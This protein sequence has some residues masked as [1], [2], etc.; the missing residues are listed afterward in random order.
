MQLK[1]YPQFSWCAREDVNGLLIHYS[2]FHYR[3]NFFRT[4]LEFIRVQLK[5]AFGQL[6]RSMLYVIEK[7]GQIQCSV[8]KVHHLKS[9]KKRKMKKAT[10]WK[11]ILVR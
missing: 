3:W 5:F 8:F 11:M 6:D 10:I 1:F 2:T 7:S 4:F 9:Q